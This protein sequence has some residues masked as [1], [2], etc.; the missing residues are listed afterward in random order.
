MECSG[1]LWNTM[2]PHGRFEAVWELVTIKGENI[3]KN[4][5]TPDITP[6]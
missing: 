4:V 6:S 1:R 3:K 5:V 2:E